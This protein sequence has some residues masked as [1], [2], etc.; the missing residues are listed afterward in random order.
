MDGQSKLN[1]QM[2]Q[3]TR[4][5][6]ISFFVRSKSAKIGLSK[7]ISMSKIIRILLRKISVENKSLGPHFL[8]KTFFGIFNFN[9]ALL[10]K[11]CLFFDKNQFWG[12][13]KNEIKCFLLWL[14]VPHWTSNF[15]YKSLIYFPLNL[16][17]SQSSHFHC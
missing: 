13:S 2:L 17:L 7:I 15:D 10:L 6:I 4:R 5:Q 16:L 3:I 8:L 14:S 1:A 9:T 12:F 11:S